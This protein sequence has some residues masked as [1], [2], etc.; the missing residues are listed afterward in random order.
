MRF[1]ALISGGKDSVHSLSQGIREGHE[2]VV[3]LHI[4][5]EEEK[6]SYM[7]QHAGFELVSSIA[8]CLQVPLLVQKTEGLA[9]NRNLEYEKTEKDEVE[10]LFQ[11]I[12]RAKKEYGIEG[13]SS[14]AIKSTYQYLRVENICKRLGLVSLAYLWGRNQRDL[15]KEMI[16]QGIEAVVVKAGEEPLV[17]LVGKS[18]EEV[19]RKYQEYIREQI[20]TSSGRLK[21]EDYNICGEGGEYETITLNAPVFA[22]K[23]S[24]TDS[25][26]VKGPDGVAVL[27]IHSHEL[28]N[29]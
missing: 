26:V 8:E 6:D 24:I 29:K 20:N 11:L 3:S 18:I 16:D 13:V 4:K 17:G 15:L 22:K 12:S 23:I 25:S 2:L 10:D 27:K 7:F 21:E 28:L 14:G 9:V 19:S 1:A 5:T